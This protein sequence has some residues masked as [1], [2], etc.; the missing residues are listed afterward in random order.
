MESDMIQ[1]VKSRR[2]LK[3][4]HLS[5]VLETFLSV[6]SIIFRVVGNSIFIMSKRKALVHFATIFY[7]L[8]IHGATFIL[9]AIKS[10]SYKDIYKQTLRLVDPNSITGKASVNDFPDFFFYLP[11]CC[12]AK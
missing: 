3:W 4:V 11:F 12:P 10:M 8:Y 7:T 5:K 6:S 2:V 9:C 1:L